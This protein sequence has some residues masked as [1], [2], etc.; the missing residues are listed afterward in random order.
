[1]R[2]TLPIVVQYTIKDHTFIRKNISIDEII[3]KEYIDIYVNYIR[4]ID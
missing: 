2:L 1:M 3:E 4:A